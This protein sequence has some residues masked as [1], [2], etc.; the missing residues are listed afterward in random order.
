[1]KDPLRTGFIGGNLGAIIFFIICPLKQAAGKSLPPFVS[2]LLAASNSYPADQ[3]DA[4]IFFII[5]NGIWD[6]IFI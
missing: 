5:T 3:V 6:V 1:M 2:I 4:M